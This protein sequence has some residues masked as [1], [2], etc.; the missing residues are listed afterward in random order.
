M[1]LVAELMLIHFGGMVLNDIVVVGN[2]DLTLT[3]SN[4]YLTVAPPHPSHYDALSYQTFRCQE[5]VGRRR[6]LR[7]RLEMGDIVTT[8]HLIAAGGW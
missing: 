4:G 8:W 6:V 2:R 1:E 5:V 7:V 3:T